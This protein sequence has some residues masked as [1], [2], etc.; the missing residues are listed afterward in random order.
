MMFVIVNVYSSFILFNIFFILLCPSN[1]ALKVTVYDRRLHDQNTWLQVYTGAS[2]KLH[3]HSDSKLSFFLIVLDNNDNLRVTPYTNNKMKF[4]ISNSS[5]SSSASNH[6]YAVAS[7]LENTFILCITLK[8]C[9]KENIC[10]SPIVVKGRF[11]S[12][13]TPLSRTDKVCLQS[14][15]SCSVVVSL[16]N[17]TTASVLERNGT[18]VTKTTSSTTTRKPVT[19]VFGVTDR[20]E[21]VASSSNL[22][23]T[24]LMV[25]VP[26]VVVLLL[27]IITVTC[28]RCL[29]HPRKPTQPAKDNFWNRFYVNMLMREECDAEIRER[30]L[31]DD[32]ELQYDYVY[33]GR[34][35]YAPRT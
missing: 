33:A 18:H 17:V 24:I 12:N 4:Y 19:S 25:M 8:I 23:A 13:K 31:R 27:A 2:Y 21:I 20:P 10:I 29:R 7:N 32:I 28:I 26:S 35:R 1:L 15:V 9:T 16:S 30:E 11:V 34:P 22:T 3:F 14:V 6:F 5:L